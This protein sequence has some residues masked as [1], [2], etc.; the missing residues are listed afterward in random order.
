MLFQ[1][2]DDKQECVGI[3]KEGEL[4]FSK[5]PEELT[6]TWSYSGFLKYRDIEYAQIYCGGKSLGDVCPPH[7][8]DEY[9]KLRAKGT[10][11]L[12][13]FDKAKI[14]L[15]ENC[16]FDMVPKQYLLE[17]CELKNKIT[18]HVFATYSR[19]KN[20]DFLCSASKL[21]HEISYQKL[22]IDPAMIKSQVVNVDVR[23]FWRKV[24]SMPEHYI[25][26][27]LYGTR[28]GRLTTAQ[29]SFPI[30]TVAKNLRKVV[31]P[32]NAYFVEL[33]YNAAE[34]RTLLALSG[35]PQPEEDLHEW[36]VK[37]VFHDAVLAPFVS[38]E[39][40][41]KRIF[42]WLYS[43]NSRVYN[44]KAER[45]YSPSEVVDNYYSNGI[46]STLFG[47][48]LA[49]ESDKALNYIIQ[50]TTSDI[51]LQQAVKISEALE[52]KQSHVAFL[53][54]D[55]VVLDIAEEERDMVPELRDIFS[56][57]M[58]GSYRTQV[59]AGRNFGA[60]KEINL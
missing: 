9:T 56:A 28:T 50:S 38:R 27:D 17:W 15:K 46:A 34:L 3:Y 7:L 53:M 52:G 33:D 37:N 41:K 12:K 57:T 44:H 55:S 54:H 36:N 21:L 13:S 5:L 59:S 29:G 58:L 18:E 22:N 10:A 14:N 30:L 11:F 23:K 6:Q 20:H 31:K 48:E 26:Y 16:F 24:S 51:C 32:R 60:L 8:K 45:V 42:Q 4:F 40:A 35:K 1:T 2:L 43:G 39:E 25:K 49:V 19:P 47:R